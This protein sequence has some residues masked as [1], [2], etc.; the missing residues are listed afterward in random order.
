[1]H[2]ARSKMR[3]LSLDVS[4]VC[5]HFQ[6]IEAYRQVG[7]LISAFR[8]CVQGS[9]GVEAGVQRL[10]RQKIPIASKGDRGGVSL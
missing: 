10:G 2:Y 7:C 6:T 4:H 5:Q 1:M 3:Y 8:I 9:Q